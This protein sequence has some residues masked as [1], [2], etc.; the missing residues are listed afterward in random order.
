MTDPAPD[1]AP[2]P[3]TPYPFRWWGL[4]VLCCAIAILAIDTTVLNFAIPAITTDLYPSATQMLWVVDVYAF[5]VA[6]LLVTM[7][8]VGDRI[9]RRRLLLWGAFFFGV[10][11]VAAAFSH[12]PE[13]LQGAAGATLMPS[14]LSL[15]RAMF[16]NAAERA[17][18]VS[19]WVAVYSVGAAVGPLLGGFLLENFHW[20]SVFLINVPLVAVIILGGLCVLP[21]S[22]PTNTGLFDVKGAVLSIIALFSL[23]YV[24]KVLPV[25]GPS[26][27]VALAAV[28]TA[29]TG[30]LL[31]RHVRSTPH[32]LI[33]VALLKDPVYTTVVVVNGV[34]MFLY[35]GMLFYLSQYLQ[36]VL[37]YS[38]VQAALMMI[39]GLLS[40]LVATLITGR[41]MTGLSS[42]KILIR[43]FLITAVASLILGADALAVFEHIGGSGVWL[44]IG[45]AVLGVGVGMIDPVSNDFI[46]SAAPPDRAG[47]AASLSETGY[48]LG[49][50]FGTAVLGSVLLAVYGYRL[51]LTTHVPEAA[52]ESLTRAHELAAGDA[53]V[54]A[55]ADDA[56]RLGVVASSI[57]AAAAAL[58]VALLV[59]RFVPKHT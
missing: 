11:S 5:V 35:I 41:I 10:A 4:A 27:L 50:A 22:A 20:G 36:L 8:T 47:A 7:G 3:A 46:L 40:S 59:A 48:E 54:I 51:S 6:A 13:M 19:L 28:T 24:V 53:Q 34:S 42:R 49:G 29:V 37:G 23:V 17:R 44:G 39:P 21:K 26:L 52:L 45:F 38:P 43:A 9:G 15:I 55:A 33:D 57:V 18:A 58:G 32:P 1:T 25:E 56:F 14:T 31:T 16:N 30:F 12:T 2:D